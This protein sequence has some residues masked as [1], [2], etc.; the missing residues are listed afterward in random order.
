[1]N[2]YI[3]SLVTFKQ[4]VGLFNFVIIFLFGALTSSVLVAEPFFFSRVIENIEIYISTWELDRAWIISDSI[5]WGIYIIVSI[6]LYFFYR[7]HFTDKN[8]LSFYVSNLEKSINASLYTEY[9]KLLEKKP[10]ELIKW[11]EKWR[12][13][14]INFFFFFFLN[15]YKNLSWI[16]VILL[17]MI[18][19]DIRMTFLT[20]W[21]IPVVIFIWY[22]FN[23]KTTYLQKD[24]NDREDLI[25]WNI[26]DALSNFTLV[27]ILWLERSFFT[28][29]KREENTLLD[30]QYSVSYR[31]AVAHNYTWGLIAIMRLIVLLI[32]FKF[33]VEDTLTFTELL[34]FFLYIW[35][36]YFPIG[37]IFWEL[38]QVQRWWTSIQSYYDEYY[39]NLLLEDIHSW[40]NIKKSQWNIDFKNISFWYTENQ[41]IINNLSLSIK[42]WQ[43]IALVWNTWAGK[44]TL[45]N[46]LLRFWEVDSGNIS[47]DGI[48]ISEIKKSSLRSHVWVVS[49][50]NSLF[51]LSI[52]ENLKFAN[53][54]ATQKQIKQA[55][56]NAEANFVF[57]LKDGI[58]T[59]IWERG[60]KLSGGEKQRISIARL[61]LKNPEILILDEATSALDNIT[62]KKIEKA[63]RKLMKWKT[64]IIIAHRLSTIMHADMIYMLENGS[65]VEQWSYIE[66]MN[67]KSK[68]Y[69]LA[70]P[71]NLILW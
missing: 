54:K 62:E 69:N 67:K 42:A 32:G 6:L 35:W 28:R 20:L 17:F 12:E 23:K 18:F 41:R 11:I 5:I 40:K 29:F 13:S 60:L 66:L 55:L 48:N 43:K 10:G 25:F 44:S 19:I 37:Q 31:W 21:W 34:L 47:L 58:K 64:S 71:D 70:N 4:H 16:F 27:K 3:K 46:L 65:I 68:F 45:V 2:V 53:P 61:F 49:Q 36:I 8:I 56:I 57:D 50:D 33:V 30:E 38:R 51:N 14:F 52:E 7:Y 15:A 63:L 9:W 1:M 39:D 26:S 24:L 59:V 22:F